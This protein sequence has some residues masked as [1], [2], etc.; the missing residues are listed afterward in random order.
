MQNLI[1]EPVSP[2][3]ERD[4]FR[5]MFEQAAFGVAQ[6]SLE[7]RWLVVNQSLCDIL[8]YSRSDLLRNSLADISRFDSLETEAIECRRL[9]AGEI[10][11]FS[12]QKRHLRSNGRVVWLKATITVVRDDVTGQPH[13]YLAVVEDLTPTKKVIQQVLFDGDKRFRVL[14]DHISDV[15]FTLDNDLKCTYWNRTAENLTGIPAREMIGKNPGSVMFHTDR[16]VSEE[17]YRA[18]LATQMV[19]SFTLPCRIAR[20]D[21]LFEVTAYPSKDGLSVVAK[22]TAS[23]QRAE[24]ALRRLAAIVQYNDD[25]ILSVTAEGRITSWNRGAVKLYGYSEAEILGHDVAQ[26]VPANLLHESQ[27][28]L[29]T[30]LAGMGVQG[31]ET[32]RLNKQ[33]ELVDVSLSVSP[34]LDA[35]AAII[36]L[37]CIARDIGERKKAETALKR[38]VV[39]DELMTGILT[40]FTTCRSEEVDAS[41]IHALQVTAEFL[42]VD[43]AHL[44]LFS[45]DRSCWSA[46]H[47]WCAEGL[48][49]YSANF[50]AVPV[51]TLAWSEAM[52]LAGEVIRINSVDDYPPEAVAE[53]Q[54]AHTRAGMRSMLQVPIRGPLGVIAGTVSF[55][56]H[57]RS[58]VWSDD[59]VSHC[60]LVGDAIATLLERQRAEGALRN[61]EEKFAKAFEASPAMIAVARVSDGCYVEVN[62]AFEQHTGLRRSEILGKRVTDAGQLSDLQSLTHAFETAIGQGSLRNMEARIRRKNGEILIVLLSAEVIE[63]DGQQCVLTVAED[64]TERHQAVDALRE[65]EERFRV[66]ADSAP[67]MMW[68]A[69]TDK[70][71][72]DFN[73]GW[74]EF[75]GRLP[76]QEAGEGW[77]RGVH[78]SDRQ[79]CMSVYHSAF[80]RRRPFTVEY[81]LRN[82]NGEYRWITNTGVP[83]F[84]PDGK[85][86]GYIGCCIDVH[87]QKQAELARTDLSRRL[88]TAQEAERTRIARE[89]HDGIGQALAVLGIQMQ[90]AEKPA[91]DGKKSPSITELCRKVKD[92]G[93][94]VSRLSHQLHSSE[95]EFLGLA[96]AVKSLCREFSEQYPIKV[97]CSCTDVPEELDNE[98]AL[99]F[100]RIVQEAMHN[101]AKHSQAAEVQ[102]KLASSGGQLV[103][104]VSDNGVGFEMT[105]MRGTVGLGM[106][107]MRERMHLIGG[108]FEIWSEPGS[109]TRIQATAYRPTGAAQLAGRLPAQDR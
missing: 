81:R 69:G 13:S 71:W 47:E 62:R 107:S 26:L 94:Q 98:V 18:V 72:S 77:L 11:S 3:R 44:C 103:L 74:L 50:Q 45:P 75:T 105:K 2:S 54:N 39:F 85:F 34:I 27:D 64:I 83:R 79:N 33:G 37:S 5:V 109:G 24:Q 63:F 80:D 89:L 15:F 90:R 96:A 101:V 93:T 28:I 10:Q 12:V 68:M 59:D 97:T 70:G 21:F 30:G 78:R 31:F 108:E 58:V 14:A 52:V 20:R 65:S 41:V 92:I 1:D 57:Y 104:K 100:L 76:E 84:M 46:T 42:A 22:D 66:M 87:D 73:R 6:V 55:D 95:L 60:K 56:C 29:Q 16:S 4:A 23:T 38:Q 102:V 61:S 106:V 86:V 17:A 19:R 82:R 91:A 53:R 36:G 67:I 25:A 51:G 88:M 35:N 43:H 49:T 32:Q 7:G 40:R 48:E 99:C 9:L 8:G